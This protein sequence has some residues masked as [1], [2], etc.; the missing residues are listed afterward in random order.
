MIARHLR[1]V[2]TAG[3]AR[4]PAPGEE[5][6]VLDT[7]WTPLAG[8]RPD[9][10]PL[11]PLLLDV[12]RGRRPYAEAMRLVDDWAGASDIAARLEV[13][14]WSLW[15]RRRLVAW[16]GLHDRLIWRWVLA[17]LAEDGPIGA[18]ELATEAPELRDVGALLAENEGWTWLAPPQVRPA[19]PPPRLRLPWPIDPILWR[20]GLHPSQRAAPGRTAGP[21]TAT[22][23]RRTA[24]MLDR[25]RALAREGPRLLV[26]TAPTTHQTVAVGG[27]INSHD[28]FLGPIV[29]ALAGTTLEPVVLEVGSALTDEAAWARLQSPG[30]ERVVPGS[31]IGPSF[32]E[33]ADLAATEA[34]VRDI[35]AR[36]AGPFAALTC[37]GL[38]L[39]P[40]L[41][42]ELDAYA[43]TGLASELRSAARTRRFLGLVRPAAVLLINEYSRPEWLVA[44]RRAGIP[45]VAVQ[46]GIIH[47]L[48]AGYVVPSRAGLPLAE[49]THLFG[50]YEARILTELSVYQPADV[51]VSGAPRLDLVGDP[52]TGDGSPSDGAATRAAT[53]ARLGVA[54]GARLVVFSS[55]SSAAVRASTIAAAFEAILDRP[56]PDVH[57]VVKLHPGE[58]D[59]AFYRALV[60]GIA[61]AGGFAPPPLTVIK[62]IDLFELLR[63][64]DAHIGIHS[65]VLTD[66]VAAGTPNLIVTSLAEHDLI[67]YVAAGVA[68]RIRDGGNL[69]DA[70]ADR[71]EPARQAAARHA[72]LS[73]HFAPGSSSRRIAAELLARHGGPGKAGGG[74]AQPANDGGLR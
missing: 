70:L 61:L 29:D 47:P 64:A 24:A 9:V 27:A 43:G 33:P 72:F 6:I 36:L 63:A 15:Y 14:G 16:R 30:R 18:L 56:W 48:H 19:P 60:D 41:R 45:A 53:R 10:R 49:R 11:R 68:R 20:L 40:W 66:A 39:S 65:T 31:L 32:D 57:L 25:V 58:D 13:D 8:D 37:D 12:L 34:S 74:A 1:F 44:C 52:A 28:P 3:E 4:P 35:R 69:L 17:R 2:A 46:H 23:A 42:A 7:S 21:S 59:G 73:D 54:D 38:D 22:V 55:T 67:G 71:E 26:L 50:P 5:T 51:V 62:A